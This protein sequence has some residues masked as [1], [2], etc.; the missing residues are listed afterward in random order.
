[1]VIISSQKNVILQKPSRHAVYT[2]LMKIYFCFCFFRM[3]DVPT[4]NGYHPS[5]SPL[6]PSSHPHSPSPNS[7]P[8][9]I[10]KDLRPTN[11]K[12]VIPSA[13][14]QGNGGLLGIP[15]T[16]SEVSVV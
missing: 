8:P 13:S 15:Q 5:N 9:P 14:Q 7:S 12:V 1:M 3:L 10:K 16:Q 4:Q 11:L 6:P 2:F